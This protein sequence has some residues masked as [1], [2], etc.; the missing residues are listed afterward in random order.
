[1]KVSELMTM[2]QNVDPNA[3]IVIEENGS[4]YSA[5]GVVAGP[6]DR[7]AIETMTKLYLF[8]NLPEDKVLIF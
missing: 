4:T 8:E 2:L 6:F 1:M 7:A 3:E 5:K